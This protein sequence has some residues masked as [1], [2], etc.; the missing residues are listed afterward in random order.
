MK[1]SHSQV[2]ENMDQL[3]AKLK[4]VFFIEPR[5]YLYVAE[6]FNKRTKRYGPR[7]SLIFLL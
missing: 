5:I 4:E 3:N 6:K 1:E 7:C 2:L